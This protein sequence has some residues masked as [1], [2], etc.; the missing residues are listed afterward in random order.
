MWRQLYFYL[1]VLSCH[2]DYGEKKFYVHDNFE[3]GFGQKRVVNGIKRVWHGDDERTVDGVIRIRNQYKICA[4]HHSH[5]R[6]RQRQEILQGVSGI[7]ETQRLCLI[8]K[9]V[10]K[11]NVFD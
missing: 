2:T 11:V 3:T 4:S 6:T 8:N 7:V 1:A 5:G 10:A 9:Y